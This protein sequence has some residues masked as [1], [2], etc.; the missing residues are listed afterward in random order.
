MGAPAPGGGYLF[1]GG[2][3][4]IFGPPPRH[5]CVP[6]DFEEVR[7]SAEAPEDDVHNA[8][9]AIR[10]NGVAIKGEMG[11]P[12]KIGTPPEHSGPPQKNWDPPPGKVG[13]P[14]EKLGPPSDT[15]GHPWRI[16]DPL[17]NLGPPPR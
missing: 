14:Q 9:M 7:V 5:A 8:I 16:W 11:P 12:R 3:S 10:R 1:W 13:A 17:D 6:V 15:L 2:E 4:K